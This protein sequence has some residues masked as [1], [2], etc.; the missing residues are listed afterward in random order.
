MTDTPPLVSPPP[1]IPRFEHLTN[2]LRWVEAETGPGWII[3]WRLQQLWVVQ[4][5]DVR[6]DSQ[7][8]QGELWGYTPDRTGWFYLREEWR[9]VPVV[10]AEEMAR[11]GGV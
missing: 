6:R 11:E 9:D 1:D 5:G 3:P 7:P 2:G 4:D 10:S 8:T